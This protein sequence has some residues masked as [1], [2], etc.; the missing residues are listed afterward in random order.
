MTVRFDLA[1]AQALQATITECN[2]ALDE[3]AALLSKEVAEIG[4]WWRGES[5]EAFSG[6][7]N[8]TGK[9][10][11]VAVAQRTADLGAYLSKV[12]VAK[13]DFESSG[14]KKFR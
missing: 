7:F 9:S 5:F 2:Q 1:R 14:A 12:A 11:V 3:L 8:S 6:R 4:L 10:S 13:R